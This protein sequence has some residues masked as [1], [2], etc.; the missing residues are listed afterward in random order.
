MNRTEI[1]NLVMKSVVECS[2]DMGEPTYVIDHEDLKEYLMDAVD[3]ESKLSEVESIIPTI[4]LD[5]L[6]E[7]ILSEIEDEMIFIACCKAEYAL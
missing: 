3:D 6:N 5:S 2:I 1:E 7:R 4:D